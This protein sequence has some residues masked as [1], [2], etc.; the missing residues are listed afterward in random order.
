MK[1][2]RNINYLF[3]NCSQFLQNLESWELDN[4][5]YVKKIYNYF[6]YKNDDFLKK[7]N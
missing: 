3:L 7:K 5:K 2:V 1:N 6:H 4:V